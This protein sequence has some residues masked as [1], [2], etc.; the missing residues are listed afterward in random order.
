MSGLFEEVSAH[1]A[2]AW[3]LTGLLT[4]DAPL[5]EGAAFFV[6][7]PAGGTGAGS[8]EGSDEGSGEGS[9]EGTAPVA[10]LL[11]CEVGYYGGAGPGLSGGL[12]RC[13]ATALQRSGRTPSDVD[14][15]VPGAGGHVRLGL[16]ERRATVAEL[17][18]M[19]ETIDIVPALG[20][21]YSASGALQLT[22]L[23]ATTSGGRAR[24]GL[25]TSMSEDGGAGALLVSC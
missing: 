5:G 20:E 4:P 22:A 2:W 11:G 16:M 14:V 19:P 6:I 7:E 3:H 25:V 23:L 10:E 24:I 15:V 8:A 13:I 12:R 17:G 21:A 18:A 1:T 9:G